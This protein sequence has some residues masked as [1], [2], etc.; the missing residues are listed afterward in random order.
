M[1]IEIDYL[2]ELLKYSKYYDDLTAC[3]NRH[4]FEANLNHLLANLNNIHTKVTLFYLDLDNFK[5]I[6]DTFGYVLGDRLL[7]EVTKRIQSILR[8]EDIIGRISGDEFAIVVS[9]LS[10]ED[11]IKLIATKLLEQI[12]KPYP[13]GRTTI[14]ISASIGIANYPESGKEFAELLK[15]ADIALDKAKH[16]GRGTFQFYTNKLLEDFHQQHDLEQHLYDAIANEEFYLVYQPKFSITTN[17]LIGIE[18]LLRWQHPKFGLILPEQFIPIAEAS[19]LIVPIGKWVFETAC[20]QFEEWYNITK[21][22]LDFTIA[23][24]LSP[25]QLANNVFVDAM[26]TLIKSI[27]IPPEKI[28]LEITESDL[29]NDDQ[30]E[31]I[32]KELKN[33]SLQLAIDDFGKGHSSMSRL[34]D[35]PFKTLKIDSSFVQGLEN[36]PVDTA[37]VKSIINMGKELGI[38]VIAEGIETQA[39][40]D[41][42]RHHECPQGQGFF[43]SKPL[44]VDEMT[45]FLQKNIVE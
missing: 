44:S 35:F 45:A 9:D 15:A 40:L 18:C 3:Y 29:M 7:R 26:N 14:Y 2:L 21:K 27:T 39:Q 43:Y 31:S 37:I 19:G 36:N 17:K 5:S 28:E 42:L 30:N 16:V 4:G 13:L 6:N 20:Q 34:K 1:E 12:G 24:N 8:R 33:I 23:I 10:S 32:L 11:E 38:N 41:F 22:Q 25:K